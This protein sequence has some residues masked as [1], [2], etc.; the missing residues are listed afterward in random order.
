MI[1]RDELIKKVADTMYSARI[2]NNVHRGDIVEMMVYSELGH[3]WN[4]VG[5]GWHP[6]DLQK[7]KGE[8]R[9][10]VQVKHCAALQLWGETK[11]LV[12]NFGWKDKK[13]M[14]F[15]EYYPDEVIEEKGWFCDVFIFGL[16]LQNDKK[17]ADQ[18]NPGEW[19]FL[20]IPTRDLE[21]EQKTM[22]LNKALKRWEPVLLSDLV[23]KVE[24][25]TKKQ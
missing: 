6:W 3:E 23:K 15:D 14:Y 16:H 11:Q 4:F 25:V 12:L 2:L 5:L 21:A 20:V 7:G 22:A 17:I 10:R 9:V 8:D 19:E 13:P 24:T 18:V 1:K